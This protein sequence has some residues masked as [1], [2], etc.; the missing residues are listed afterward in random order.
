MGESLGDYPR[1]MC[2]RDEDGEVDPGR[3][4]GAPLGQ[5]GTLASLIVFAILLF[6]VA[7]R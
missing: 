6:I 1:E 5:T 2:P 3:K 4:P 7:F